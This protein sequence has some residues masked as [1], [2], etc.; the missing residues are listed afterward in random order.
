[1]VEPL[2]FAGLLNVVVDDTFGVIDDDD[3]DNH[4][5]DDDDDEDEVRLV[6]I[7]WWFF[8][9]FCRFFVR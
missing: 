3:N 5:N 9:Q 7:S 2:L 4:D 1:M 8:M 6:L